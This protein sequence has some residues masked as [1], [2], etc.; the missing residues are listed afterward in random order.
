[1][2]AQAGT[3]APPAQARGEVSSGI[4]HSPG[5][6][7]STPAAQQGGAQTIPK[8]FWALAFR[9]CDSP[10]QIILKDESGPCRLLRET[11]RAWPHQLPCAR[12][13][14]SACGQTERRAALAPWKESGGIW[15]C[16][17]RFLSEERAAFC[18]V[19]FQPARKMN[20]LVSM[21]LP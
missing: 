3:G 14:H 11:G 19:L 5:V 21:E 10:C 17:V 20:L 6:C 15:G 18:F 8:A 1:M 4:C 7:L 12:R 16:T 9:F 13:S 2:R